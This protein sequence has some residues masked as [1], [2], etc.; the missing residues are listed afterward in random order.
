MGKVVSFTNK[1]GGVFVLRFRGA[2][3][4]GR[5]VCK[6]VV[7]GDGGNHEVWNYR[8][9]ESEFAESF[10]VGSD[11]NYQCFRYAESAGDNDGSRRILGTKGSI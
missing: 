8:I 9:P 11:A 1:K 7:F 3:V 6:V 4:L 2:E 5:R 10:N